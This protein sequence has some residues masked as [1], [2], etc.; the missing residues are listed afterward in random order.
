MTF[1]LAAVIAAPSQ[2]AAGARLWFALPL[3]LVLILVGILFD[4]LGVSATAASTVPLN[5]MASK[6]VQGA[7]HAIRIVRHAGVVSSFSNDLIGDIVG[8]LT[9]ALG[10]AIAVRVVEGDG[11][12]R[13]IEAL[14]IACVAALT[15][16]GKALGKQVAINYPVYIVLRAGQM[17]FWFEKA[18]GIRLLTERT[19]R[20]GK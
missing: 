15:V 17:L 3:L 9:G 5:A 12:R 2:A 4:M 6:R 11:I 7:K 10:V 16:G 18:F 14:A 8:T 1:V 13:L 20:K 19:K